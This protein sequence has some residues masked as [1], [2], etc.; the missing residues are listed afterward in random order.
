MHETILEG[1]VVVVV[2][3]DL[4]LFECRTCPLM[5]GGWTQLSATGLRSLVEHHGGLIRWRWKLRGEV[6]MGSRELKLVLSIPHMGLNWDVPSGN[7]T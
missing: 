7:L 5:P 1:V 4:H 3:A 6:P 2:V